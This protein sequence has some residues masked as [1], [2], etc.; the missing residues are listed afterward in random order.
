MKVKCEFD[1]VIIECKVIENM[2][3][4]GGYFV[5]AIEYKESERIVV[6]TNGNIWKLRTVQERLGI[7]SN[8]SGQ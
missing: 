6:K 8:Y 5:K 4:Q 2:G 7:R 3:Y 1:G